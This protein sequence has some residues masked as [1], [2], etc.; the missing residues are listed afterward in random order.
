MPTQSLDTDA[1][2]SPP[3]PRTSGPRQRILFLNRSYWPDAEATGQ[4]LTE[5]CEDLAPAADVTVIAGQP[6][7]NLGD[8]EFQPRG[9]Q[10]RH[11]V[12]IRRVWNSRFSKAMPIGRVTNYFSFLFS[13]GLAALRVPRPDVIVVE[14]DP[15]LLCLLA[16]FLRLWYG[17]R[18]VVYLQDIYPDLAVALGKLRAG[19]PTRLLRRAMFAVYRRA[20][21]VVVLSRDMQELL[22]DSGVSA[23]RIVCVPNW[24]DTEV[25]Y[26]EKEDNRFRKQHG[27][28]DRFVVMYSGNMGLCQRLEDLIEAADRLRDQSRIIFL[29]IGEGVKKRE[30]QETVGSRQLTN[31]MFLPYQPKSQLADSLSAADLHLVPLDPRIASYLMPS[32]LYGILASGS[33]V[34]TIAPAH[35]EL[36]QIV[37]EQQVGIVVPP[38]SPQ[39]LADAILRCCENP[40]ELFEMGV[41]ARHLAVHQYDR[42]IATARFGEL[43]GIAG[44]GRAVSRSASVEPA[45]AEPAP[46]EPAPTESAA[47]TLR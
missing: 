35:C 23:D 20:D 47:V 14:T 37:Q 17:A 19:W 39:A 4:L 9:W 6:N 11:G 28:D 21:R 1:A 7:H 34:A 25:I 10:R 2:A 8:E 46:A 31:V 36:A 24:V 27:L 16:G 45:P 26:P 5:L 40:D 22:C 43:L 13:A 42:S 29:L 30:L 41:R 32:K 18:L 44:N 12:S 38:E 15:P 33:A 3:A